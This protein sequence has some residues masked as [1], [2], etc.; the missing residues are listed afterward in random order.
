M[1]NT[2]HV[3]DPYYKDLPLF[4]FSSEHNHN[5][6]SSQQ[7]RLLF[8]AKLWTKTS[9]SHVVFWVLTNSTL[10]TRQFYEFQVIAIEWYCLS[11]CIYI[12]INAL[13]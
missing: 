2:Y 7:N 8:S 13:D 3:K 1:F 5:S 6:I 10:K 4:Y 12:A 11:E 9:Y